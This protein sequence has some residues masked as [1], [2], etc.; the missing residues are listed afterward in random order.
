MKIPK[1]YWVLAIIADIAQIIPF[2]D[3][4]ITLPCQ[5]LLWYKWLNRKDLFWLV[6][7]EDIGGDFIGGFGDIIPLN[8]I[9]LM[10]SK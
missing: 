4:I 9:F 1:K 5:Y 7:T 2:F 6:L 8:V 10:G 3:I